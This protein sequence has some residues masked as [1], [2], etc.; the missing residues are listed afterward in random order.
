MR[1]D[2]PKGRKA[3][4]EAKK[5]ALVA[6]RQVADSASSK[7]STDEKAVAANG[8]KVAVT[9]KGMDGDEEDT[10]EASD[11]IENVKMAVAPPKARLTPLVSVIAAVSLPHHACLRQH[12]PRHHEAYQLC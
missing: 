8:E 6:S 4:R 10:D 2:K 5:A 11:V 12:T 7:L 9:L 3:K 1:Q